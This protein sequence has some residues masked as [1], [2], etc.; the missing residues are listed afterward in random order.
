MTSYMI[1]LYKSIFRLLKYNKQTAHFTHFYFI[2]LSY[3]YFVTFRTLRLPAAHKHFSRQF[4]VFFKPAENT[5]EKAKYVKI[6][7][8]NS[9]SVMFVSP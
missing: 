8:L 9:L 1:K 2:I 4:F 7:T 3:L 5:T 6:R